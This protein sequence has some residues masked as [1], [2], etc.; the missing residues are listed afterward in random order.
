MYVPGS[1]SSVCPW[2]SI[3]R[4]TGPGRDQ[5]GAAAE[6]GRRAES[7]R[8]AEQRAARDQSGA[9][10]ERAGRGTAGGRDLYLLGVNGLVTILNEVQLFTHTYTLST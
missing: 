7:V 3:E 9:A 10:G 1:A 6:S 8:V 2:V 5:S 4:P